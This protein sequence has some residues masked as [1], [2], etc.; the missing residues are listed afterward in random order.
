MGP[1]IFKMTH[2]PIFGEL[3]KFIILH[4]VTT[5]II[6]EPE[7][8]WIVFVLHHTINSMEV[9]QF[10]YNHSIRKLRLIPTVR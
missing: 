3:V 5:F 4:Y 2:Y 9:I 6:R 7:Q 8:R 1:L 10:L